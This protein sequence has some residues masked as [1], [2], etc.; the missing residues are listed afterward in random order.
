MDFCNQMELYLFCSFIGH[1]KDKKIS[2]TKFK[3]QNIFLVL[4]TLAHNYGKWK[5][6][7]KVIEMIMSLC[8]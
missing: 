1:R 4:L 5:K 6:K 2:F 8:L 3:S 7:K